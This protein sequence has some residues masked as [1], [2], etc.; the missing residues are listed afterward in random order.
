MLCY[1]ERPAYNKA[2]LRLCNVHPNPCNT[3]TTQWIVFM[4]EVRVWG[5]LDSGLSS[6]CVK[7]YILA[8]VSFWVK[9]IGRVCCT[10]LSLCFHSVRHL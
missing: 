10:C 3:A 4:Q 7:A 5:H 6:P 2:N 9:E 1:Y 8:S